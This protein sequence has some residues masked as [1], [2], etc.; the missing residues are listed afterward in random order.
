[1]FEESFLKETERLQ[2]CWSR[3]G[4]RRDGGEKLKGTKMCVKVT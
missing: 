2:Q 4:E 1:M 3:C